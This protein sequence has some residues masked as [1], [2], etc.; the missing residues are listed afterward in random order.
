MFIGD[1]ISGNVELGIIEK[2]LQADVKP[3]KAY[4]SVYDDKARYPAKNFTDVI[5]NELKKERFDISSAQVRVSGH[6]QQKMLH[7]LNKKL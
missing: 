2:A 6:E 3:V 4:S 7:F 5:Q 1:S